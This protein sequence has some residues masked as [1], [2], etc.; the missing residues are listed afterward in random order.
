MMP[1][2]CFTNKKASCKIIQAICF[3]GDRYRY[4]NENGN[5]CR[6]RHRLSSRDIDAEM[7]VDIM[8]NTAKVIISESNKKRAFFPLVGGMSVFFSF[9][10]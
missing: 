4:G 8:P 6:Y 7:D 9:L 1:G 10:K 3:L 2:I 5:R